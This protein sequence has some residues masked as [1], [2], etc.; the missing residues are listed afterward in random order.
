MI[1]KFD[2]NLLLNSVRSNDWSTVERLFPYVDEMKAC[3][4][5]SVYHAEGDV[6]T[7]I[8]MIAENVCNRG[9]DTDIQLLTTLYHDVAKA[10]TR[11]EIPQEDRIRISHPYH[12]RIGAQMTWIDLWENNISDIVSRLQIYKQIQWHQRSYHI[13]KKDD[14]IRAALIYVTDAPWSDLI[15]FSICDNLGRVSPHQHE[16]VESLELLK[17]WL[18]ENNIMNWTWNDPYSKLFY[19]EK[20]GRTH[21]YLAQPPKGSNVTLMCGLPGSGKDTYVAANFHGMP[22]ISLDKI[23]TDLKIKH[24]DN[25]GPVIQAALEKAKEHLRKK[26]PFVWN[27]TNLTKLARSKVIELCR[28]YDAYV[29]IHTMGTNFNTTLSGNKNRD[30]VVPE[31]VIYNMLRKWE[32]PSQ[33]EAHDI[34][35]IIRT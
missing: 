15:E 32:P 35:W 4:Q 7:H 1:N 14:M 33:T 22:V 27:S 5:D 31:N 26:E 18:E 30:A 11:E 25:Q 10:P 6:W 20:E 19:F 2:S 13:W 8:K 21:T 29:N 34:K 3:I 28:A 17:M 23:R 12:S 9:S 16:T 24:G